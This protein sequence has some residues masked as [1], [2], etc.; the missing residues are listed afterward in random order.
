[1]TI[2]NKYAAISTN[3]S[4]FILVA[5]VFSIIISYSSYKI[6]NNKNKKT[7][8]KK[9]SIKIGVFIGIVNFVGY[10]SLLTAMKTGPLSLI[11]AIH[12]TYVIITVL[13]A[14]KI[15]KEELSLKQLGF[16]ALTVIGIILLRV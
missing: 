15:H 5:Y 16:V 12:T 8:N 10:L 9:E 2:T 6:T 4:F 11:A 3:L 14:K 7:Y 13:L 1:M